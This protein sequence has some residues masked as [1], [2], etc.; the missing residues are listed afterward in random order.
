MLNGILKK[1]N[2]I[3]KTEY[4]LANNQTVKGQMVK[5]DNVV[6]GDYTANNV[7][8]AVIENGSLLCGK[9]FLD[10]FKKWELDKEKKLL[11]LYR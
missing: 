10:K 6:I 1:E 3:D 9:S 8:M 2:Y 11:I 5:T 7:V 4:V